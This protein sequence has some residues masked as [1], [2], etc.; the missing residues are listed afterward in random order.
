VEE[1][2]VVEEVE[3][4]VAVD[5]LVADSP[6]AARI[7]DNVR[8]ALFE[9][10]EYGYTWLLVLIWILLVRH[11]VFAKYLSRVLRCYAT[12]MLEATPARL[13]QTRTIATLYIFRSLYHQALSSGQSS[14]ICGDIL[15]KE[16]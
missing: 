6:V 8:G 11:D 9:N 2:N 3:D 13:K 4:T 14:K 12:L 15:P 5:V 10:G 1:G 7:L 16:V